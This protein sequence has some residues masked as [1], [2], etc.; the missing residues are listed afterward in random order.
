MFSG[1]F[2]KF[3]NPE[4]FQLKYRLC[5]K[6]VYKFFLKLDF[7]WL[8]ANYRIHGIL[9][10]LNFIHSCSLVY[11]HRHPQSHCLLHMVGSYYRL[12]G[13]LRGTASRSADK[14]TLTVISMKSTSISKSEALP[15]PLPLTLPKCKKCSQTLLLTQGLHLDS[16]IWIK[17]LHCKVYFSP[18]SLV[19]SHLWSIL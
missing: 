8:Q 11:I 17:W 9:N 4:C 19:S 13:L 5:I 10:S 2:S 15:F 1:K 18:I 16:H 12:E 7:K 14:E 3:L 6:I